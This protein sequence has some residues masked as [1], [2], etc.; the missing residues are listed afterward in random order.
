MF[1]GK[2]DRKKIPIAFPLVSVTFPTMDFCPNF[3]IKCKFSSVKQVLNAI[4]K[5]LVA[6][7]SL[8]VLYH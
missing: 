8:V 1:R 5:K 7:I 3:G 2:S 6:S 4:R